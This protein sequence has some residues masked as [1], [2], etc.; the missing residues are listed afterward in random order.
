MVDDIVDHGDTRHHQPTLHTYIA[1]QGKNELT[2]HI[3][4]V[5]ISDLYY[6]RVFDCLAEVC[7]SDP[8]L[9]H[10]TIRKQIH[11]LLNE[12]LIGEMIDIDL[13]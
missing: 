5:L 8:S 10:P 13:Q 2:S 7:E 6:H 9:H 3:Q 1:K 11:L 12:V 4:T